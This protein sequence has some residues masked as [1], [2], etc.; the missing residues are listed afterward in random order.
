M[1]QRG[2]TRT[3]LLRS[4]AEN[5]N[6]PKRKTGSTYVMTVPVK[7]EKVKGIK[8]YDKVTQKHELFNEEKSKN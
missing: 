4:Q 1:P 8:K 5:P 6:D 3:I 2:K 7:A